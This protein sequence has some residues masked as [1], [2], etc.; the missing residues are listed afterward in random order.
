MTWNTSANGDVEGFV[1]LV[2]E[3]SSKKHEDTR[4][5]FSISWVR[6][7]ITTLI[8][9]APANFMAEYVHIMIKNSVAAMDIKRGNWVFPAPNFKLGRTK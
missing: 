2:E 3:A 1:D 7:G 5:T 9:Q 8:K 4:R 6:F